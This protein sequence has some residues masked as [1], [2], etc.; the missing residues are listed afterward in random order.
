MSFEDEAC[1]T[2]SAAE[3][4]EIRGLL[5]GL[6]QAR[7]AVKRMNLARLRRMRLGIAMQPEGIPTRTEFEELL[8]SGS[9]RIDAS[10]EAIRA[11]IRRHESGNV[12]RVAVGVRGHPVPETW[13]AFDQRYQWFGKRPQSV[14]SG[15]HLFVLAVDRWKSAVVG[16][17]EA[18]TAGADKLP[19][20]PDTER[21]PWALGVRP[22]AAIPP[23]EADRVDRQQ[24][25][26]NGLPAHIT[27]AGD[28]DR[29]YQAVASS[30]PP[31][32]PQTLEQ[33]VQELDWQ[34]V[35]SDILESVGSLGK[36]AR[37]PAVIVRA[38]ELGGWTS[39]EL[40]ARAW[41]TG[42][43]VVSHIEHIVRQALQRQLGL[44]M[45]L[46]Q[47]HGV[48]S[49]TERIDVEGFGVAYRRANASKPA[50]RELPEHLADLSGL[51]RA[52]ER[53]MNLQ[54]RLADVLRGRG[55]EP[56][57]PGSW[58]PEFDL[59]FE[60]DGERFVV[61]IKS[62]DPVSLQQVRLGTGQVLEYCHL[63]SN[64]DAHV[65]PVLLIE[66]APPYP[67]DALAN[68]I[69]VQL[70]RADKLEES[71]TAL[72]SISRVVPTSVL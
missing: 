44:T 37:A 68:A 21:W 31:P 40:N 48:Y 63:L 42:S 28:I 14:T 2:F 18:V 62:G 72:L 23:L 6:A 45:R 64:A 13:S 49:L 11:V 27:D 12:F 59:A 15:A 26:Q 47:I 3:A 41:H 58:Q 67:W 17:Y 69:E 57:S 20:S 50:E 36:D 56:R 33:R 38:I 70:L 8:A 52:T 39:E 4:E 55:I 5:N 71:L 32:G 7:L 43:G 54:D 1:T 53:H 29:L 60:H 46:R 65:H 24:G 22:L 25:P 9:V 66:A 61:E 19:D 35:A 51:D 30:S 34:D 16:L 10:G